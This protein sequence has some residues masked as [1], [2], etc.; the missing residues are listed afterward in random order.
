LWEKGRSGLNVVARSI[1]KM[2]PEGARKKLR[3]EEERLE[4]NPPQREKSNRNANSVISKKMLKREGRTSQESRKSAKKKQAGEG[5]LP[6][7]ID[8]EKNAASRP[9][10]QQKRE[11][12]SHRRTVK[13]LERRKVRGQRLKY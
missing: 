5:E 1:K 2:K 11:N 13:R 8:T 3:K 9:N 7:A 10:S 6:P 4:A 12:P